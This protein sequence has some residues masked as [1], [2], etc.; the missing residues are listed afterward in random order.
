MNVTL[1]VGI[2]YHSHPLIFLCF[3]HESK[4]TV[5]SETEKHMHTHVHVYSR[6]YT[7][8]HINCISIIKKLP[9]DLEK[10]LCFEYAAISFFFL[11]VPLIGI[12]SK[13]FL[14]ALACLAVYCN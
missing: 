5:V 7:F 6:V 11:K 13:C 1:S 3:K 8:T 2:V 4:P 9:Y 12:T 14:L 10:V